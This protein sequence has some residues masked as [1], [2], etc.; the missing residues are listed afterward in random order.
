MSR[1]SCFIFYSFPS[2]QLSSSPLTLRAVPIFS[3]VALATSMS[4]KCMRKNSAKG[5]VTIDS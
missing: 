4:L 2:T 3:L 5:D 1:K